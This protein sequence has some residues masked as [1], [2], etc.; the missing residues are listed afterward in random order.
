[1][2]NF[3]YPSTRTFK[4]SEIVT[5][6]AGY[7][8]G[9]DSNGRNKQSLESNPPGHSMSSLR[10][11]TTQREIQRASPLLLL[12]MR[13][14]PDALSASPDIAVGGVSYPAVNYKSG[15]VTFTVLFDAQT[16]LPARIRTMDFDN[17]YG[18]SAYD[19]VLSD[20]RT[21]GG[22]RVA[23]SRQYQLNGRTISEAKISD[24][25]VN[26]PVSA[27][28]FAIP[29]AAKA[30]AA[31]PASGAVPY[32]WVIRRQIIG[33]YMDSENISYDA[34]AV[35][36]LR[37]VE[38]A[39]GVQHTAGGAGNS[40]IVEM[41]DYLI[42]FDAPASDW[43]SNWTIKA[44]KDKYP[45]KPIKYLVLTHHH[46]DHTGGL[47]AYAAEGATIVVGK[48]N[49]EHFRKHLAAPFTLD[50]DLSSRDLSRTQVIEVADKQVFSDGKREVSAILIDNP[51]CNG[52]MIG[53][54]GDARIGFVTDL[55]SP[56]RDPL[57]PKINP[58]LAAV[59]NG[60]KKAGISPMR[61]AGGHGAVGD[62]APL[63]ALASK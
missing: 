38:L 1:M 53:Y 4:F 24:L 9:I 33:T 26:P 30:V 10:L 61:F 32:Q 40:L 48:G 34:L 35:P 19:L 50:P 49:G 47:R 62:Y 37:L 27:E 17:V 15:N 18:D 54:V 20:W 5:A 25:V 59:F 60:V 44:A 43:Q 12:R 8:A 31:K 51:H 29:A 41:R 14:D 28:R 22:I 7:V 39:P 52:M 45:G 16:G 3:S 46:M 11:A 13:N 21:F 42:V 2:K 6:D 57:P 58:A 63:A 23:T 55:W 56:G 36:G